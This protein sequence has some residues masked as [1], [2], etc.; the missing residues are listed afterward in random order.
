MSYRLHKLLFEEIN[1][2]GLTHLPLDKMDATFTDDILK[3]IFLNE[4]I[5]ISIQFSLRF[6]PKGP[7]DNIQALV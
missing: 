1:T 3:H 5:R 7:I 6:V 4:N 2:D